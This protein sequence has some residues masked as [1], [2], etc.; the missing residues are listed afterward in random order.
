MPIKEGKSKNMEDFWASTKPIE[1][2]EFVARCLLDWLWPFALC[3]PDI[4]WN[5]RNHILNREYEESK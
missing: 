4:V 2:D 5:T 1:S 3:M